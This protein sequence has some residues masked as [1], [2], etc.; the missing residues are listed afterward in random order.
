MPSLGQQDAGAN[1]VTD[2]PVGPAVMSSG[3]AFSVVS[4]TAIA[5]E[6]HPCYFA[7]A[8]Q[9]WRRPPGATAPVAGR[10]LRPPARARLWSRRRRPAGRGRARRVAAALG[11]FSGP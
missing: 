5:G 8:D 7:G 3:T 1:R 11:A 10:R 9:R 4:I 6:M 2:E